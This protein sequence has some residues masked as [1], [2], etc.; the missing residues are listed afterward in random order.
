MFYSCINI[1]FVSF[2]CRYV[3]NEYFYNL[4]SIEK[5]IYNENR[6]CGMILIQLKMVK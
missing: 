6:R 5:V 2:C 4:Y 3:K 1:V